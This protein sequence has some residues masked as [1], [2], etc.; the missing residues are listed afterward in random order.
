MRLRRLASSSSPRVPVTGNR[1][2]SATWRARA[3]SRTG[4]ASLVSRASAVVS[5]CSPVPPGGQAWVINDERSAYRDLEVEKI[6]AW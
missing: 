4:I 2:V 3:S 6:H 5:L 1:R